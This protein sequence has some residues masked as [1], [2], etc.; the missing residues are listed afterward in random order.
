MRTLILSVMALFM[1][2]GCGATY[3]Y[4]LDNPTN[5][6]CENLCG[7]DEVTS[8]SDSSCLCINES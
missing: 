7:T 2:T 5:G 6:P 3:T 1:I 8:D 4:R